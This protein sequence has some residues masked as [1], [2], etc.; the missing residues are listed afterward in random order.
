M[1]RFKFNKDEIINYLI[2]LYAFVL[3]TSRAGIGIV[4]LL[5]L[6]YWLYR[7]DLK[8]DIAFLLQDKFVVVF[9]LFIFYSFLALFWSSNLEEGFNYAF[10][11][12]Y[13]FPVIIIATNLK[14]EYFT[15]VISAFLL[16]MLISEVLSYGMYFELI[17]WENSSTPYASPFMNHLQYAVFVT[18]TSLFLLNHIFYEK[19]IDIFYTLF[20]LSVT[21]N[22][23]INGGRIG[24]VAF[25]ATIFLVSM[26]GVKNKLKA[27][28]I[29]M[30]IVI[31]TL[32]LAY[33]FSATFKT[34]LSYTILELKEIS[35][36]QYHTSYG[37]RI[38]IAYMGTI[39]A[40]DHPIFGVG[41]GEE[42]DALKELVKTK[43]QEFSFLSERRHFH[44]I[45]VHTMVQ[46]GLLGVI[47][48]VLIFYYLYKIKIK[49]R[50]LLNVKYIF[51]T[52]F[53]ITCLTGNMF[54]QQFTM[55]FF[56]LFVG[57]ILSQNR[58]EKSKVEL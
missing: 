51:T 25:F 47:L 49:D 19:K 58:L 29:S 56:S 41:T 52:I 3:P 21:I 32:F 48:L 57:L 44:N 28:A 18:F 39:I 13:Y 4:T 1:N 37:Q 34:R 35:S 38:A 27:A 10:R 43:H 26:L 16:G 42:M 40:K 50:Y 53:L 45:F 55:A 9:L 31:A 54:H 7:S 33:N 22:L 46:L 17:E 30:S 2:V 5:M 11:Y 36:Q 8:K 15:S 6:V 20:F 24:Y 23:F 12:W 14:K